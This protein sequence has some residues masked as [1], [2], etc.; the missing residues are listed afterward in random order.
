MKKK[1]IPFI[2]LV[3]LF[4]NIAHATVIA[5]EDDCHHE[6]VHAYVAEQSMSAECGDLCDMHHLFH[7]MA[8]LSSENVGIVTQNITDKLTFKVLEYTPPSQKTSIK[9]PIA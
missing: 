4:F 9:P 2:L 8:I 6:S 3:S 7:F 5:I 1:W